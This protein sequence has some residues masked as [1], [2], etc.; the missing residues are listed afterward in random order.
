MI[1]KVCKQCG[2]ELSLGHGFYACRSNTDGRMGICKKC[3][4][5][6]VNENRAL[7]AEHYRAYK[8]AW[9]ARPENVAKRNEHR[10]TEQ[11]REAKRLSDR[12]Y[13]RFKRLEARAA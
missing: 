10:Q 1:T 3:H 13:K 12:I 2:R 11:G 8:R 9:S 4:K 5:A 7:K 6:N